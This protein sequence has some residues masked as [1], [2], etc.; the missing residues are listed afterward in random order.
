MVLP[1]MVFSAC[2][3]IHQKVSL[4]HWH[5]LA[6]LACAIGIA[7]ACAIVIMCQTLCSTKKFR[8]AAKIAKFVAT[9]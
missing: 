2:S 7:L 3:D 8:I 6:L 5:V 1:S 4:C 9:S